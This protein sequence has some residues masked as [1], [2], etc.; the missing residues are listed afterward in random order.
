MKK[1]SKLF[2]AMLSIFAL[3]GVG[4][5]VLTG[6]GGGSSPQKS[7]PV[8]EMFD[9]TWTVGEHATVQVE[10]YEGLPDKVLEDTAIVFTVKVDEGYDVDEVTSNGRRISLRNDQ[11][12][13]GISRDTEIVITV[14]E[15]V[16]QLTVISNPT[17][18]TYYAGEKIDVT[19]LVLQAT[20]GTGT[21]VTI[22]YGTDDGYSVYPITFE[23]GE[24]YFEITYKKTTI[25][26]QLTSVVEFLVKIDANGGQFTSEYLAA[27]QARNLHNYKHENGVITFTYYDDL[28]TP[29]MM[30]KKNDVTRENYSLVDWTSFNAA[31]IS[32]ATKANVDAVARWQLELVEISSVSLKAEGEKP[33]LIIEGIFR[34]ATE[35]FLYLYEGNA[36]VELK[37]DTYTGT[38]GQNFEV[39]FDL[40]RLSDKGAD[41]RGKW[42]DI[43]FNA[44]MGDTEISMEIFVNASSTI[45]VD[46]GEKIISGQYA[47][48]F[49]TYDSRLKVYFQEVTFVYEVEGHVVNGKDYLKFSGVTKNAEHFNKY[50]VISCWNDSTE[51]DGYGATIDGSG[52]FVVEYALEDFDGIIEK[53]IFF[54]VTIY[55]D[56]TKANI[57][58]GGI[59]T[60]LA[61]ADVFTSI[62]QLDANLGDIHHAFL[63]TGS[64]GLKYY[65]GY[66]WDGLML[67]IME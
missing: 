54:H 8:G 3:F 46:T 20:L 33:Y 16:G 47:Y 18:L 12:T 4:T 58:Y 11:Y 40:T 2:V 61:V 34:A 10:G 43:R 55:S 35:V 27:L 17:K 5:T 19:G 39:K 62:P 6:C 31:S 50:I 60:N 44:R 24:T 15:A 26:I 53:N 23:G 38:S 57:V 65:I 41:Y 29:V 9:V 25:R 45:E 49:A 30:P 42:M 7:E 36:Q 52:N 21:T 66:A 14:S 56:N 48:V 32:N 1:R 64:N 13:V 22:P 28:T 51:T 37:G 59:T 63:Y 67:Y